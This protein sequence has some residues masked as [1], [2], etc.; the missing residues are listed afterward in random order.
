[1]YA[2]S[3][4]PSPVSGDLVTVY[5]PGTPPIWRVPYRD[6]VEPSLVVRAP[7]AGYIVPVGYAHRV[8]TRLALHGVSCDR[9]SAAVE[10]ADVQV[11]RAS[12]AS[13]S[14]EPFEGR[15]R[16]SLDGR[17]QAERRDVPAGSLFVPV[18]Q[19]LARLVMALL[20]PQAP[21]S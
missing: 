1:G 19:P 21:D 4:K 6:R 14:T 9:V 16:V 5:D 2:Y 12:R 7:A 8:G 17:W 18:A 10:K 3:R 20:E 13:F 15:M 11:F